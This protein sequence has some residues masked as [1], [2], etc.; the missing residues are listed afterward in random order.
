MC[1][2]TVSCSPT[3]GIIKWLGDSPYRE[4]T[5]IPQDSC[6]Q[7]W[8]LFG[9][10]PSATEQ[11]PEDQ[12]GSCAWVPAILPLPHCNAN[13]FSSSP[14]DTGGGP[15]EVGWPSCSVGC[16]FYPRDVKQVDPSPPRPGQGESLPESLVNT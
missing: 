2:R 4:G 8:F 14:E 1:L 16:Q 13:G 6:S 12:V 5:Q 9:Y 10:L 7:G 3:I 11:R 15:H